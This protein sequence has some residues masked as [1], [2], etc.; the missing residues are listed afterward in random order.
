MAYLTAAVALVGGLCVS[1]LILTFGVIRRL[2][3]HTDHL[4]QLLGIGSDRIAPP[5]ATIGHFQE[6]TTD[7]EPVSNQTLTGQTLVGFFSPDCGPCK[8]LIPDFI[9]YARAVPGGRQQVLAVVVGD[10]VASLEMVAALRP[11][12]R[13]IV[14]KA[15][16]SVAASFAVGGFPAVCLLEDGGTVAASGGQ[17]ED[18]E[19]VGAVA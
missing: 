7:G 19:P 9:E 12:A 16:G 5:S 14:E 4:S 8:K 3:T 18:L 2:R 11:V 17:M 6:I 15:S 10:E 1:N 13:V